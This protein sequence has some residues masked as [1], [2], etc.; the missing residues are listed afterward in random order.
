MVRGQG[1]EIQQA[2]ASGVQVE[3]L[4]NASAVMQVRVLMEVA[5]VDASLGML[6]HPDRI[7]G[8]LQPT[9]L[10]A[11]LQPVDSRLI[12]EYVRRHV[13]HQVGVI[14]EKARAKRRI[15]EFEIPVLIVA[16]Q[17]IPLV[18]R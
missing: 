8:S 17:R 4:V 18:A 9:V 10:A 14:L 12:R 5:E 11:N 13:V 15:R 3:F 16:R 2:V 7:A 1:S 6:F